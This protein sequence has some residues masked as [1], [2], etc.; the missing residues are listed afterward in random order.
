[1]L[2]QPLIPHWL[3]EFFLLGARFFGPQSLTVRAVTAHLGASEYD[4]ETELRTDLGS[5]V[6]QFLAEEFLDSAAP[7]ADDMRVFLLKAR[8]VIMLVA[9]EMCEV[10][11]VDKSALLEKLQSTVDGNP[12]E[13]GVFLLRHL[14]Q[15]LGIEVKARLVNEFEQ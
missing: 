10:K 12:V 4:F 9:F 11:F 1:M 8:F 7:K 3:R 6:A 15:A 2:L 14:K 5:E 13:F